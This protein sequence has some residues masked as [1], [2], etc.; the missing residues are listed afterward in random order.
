MCS[1]VENP[2]TTLD[3]SVVQIFVLNFGPPDLEM[4]NFITKIS[5]APFLDLGLEPGMFFEVSNQ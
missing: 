5:V 2:F 3:F 4:F 1:A